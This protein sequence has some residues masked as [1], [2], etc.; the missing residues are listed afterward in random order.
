MYVHFLITS[1]LLFF[2]LTALA[3]SPKYPEDFRLRLTL[4]DSSTY[5]GRILK[6]EQQ[7]F[8]FY[9][10]DLKRRFNVPYRNILRMDTLGPW[11]PFLDGFH[12]VAT[13]ANGFN[14]RQGDVYYKNY[15]LSLNTVHVGLT[16]RFSMG[17]GVDLLSS[18]F[19]NEL[20]PTMVFMPK[21]TFPIRDRL[22]AGVGAIWLR[23][24]EFD[25]FISHQ[26]YYF[27]LSYGETYSNISAGLNYTVAE[28]SFIP[29]PVFTFAVKKRLSS[30][31]GLEMEYYM[32]APMEGL[33]ALLGVQFIGRRLDFSISVPIAAGENDIFL[34]PLPLLGL[35][36]KFTKRR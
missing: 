3:Q 7:Q 2:T 6:S 22:Q 32:G 9:G 8:L 25:G 36:V 16:D 20:T 30:S 17:V 5:E 14:L 34:S 33:G 18:L 10:T 27:A 26:F 11:R 24:P 4:K 13:P 15:W 35:G 21:Y 23:L 19:S 28:G 1:T 31:I 12:N 29:D